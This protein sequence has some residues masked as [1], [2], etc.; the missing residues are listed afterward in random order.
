MQVFLIGTNHLADTHNLMVRQL[1]GVLVQLQP[2]RLLLEI[3]PADLARPTASPGRYAPEM[4]LLA[5]GYAAIAHGFDWLGEGDET[6]VAAR[7]A[8]QQ[9][10]SAQLGSA[11]LPPAGQAFYARYNQE[12]APFLQDHDLFAMNSPQALQLA[13]QWI[14]FYD[15]C[16]GPFAPLADFY[17]QRALRINQAIVEQVAAVAAT[18]GRLV[19]V[20]GLSH[21]LRVQQALRQSLPGVAVHLLADIVPAAE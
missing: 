12:L 5:Q 16:S 15:W 21:V 7:L 1:K 20:I 4:C 11:D 8:E 6:A 3:R 14:T 18:P 9:N 13:G 17:R 2:A 19:V 10:L